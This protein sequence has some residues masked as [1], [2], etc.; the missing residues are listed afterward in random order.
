[1]CTMSSRCE[2]YRRQVYYSSTVLMGSAPSQKAVSTIQEMQSFVISPGFL[3]RYL[4]A[5]SNIQSYAGVLVLISLGL[6]FWA[7]PRY[8][9]KTMLVYL[10]VCSLIGSLSVVA[11]QGL[12]TDFLDRADNRRCNRSPSSRKA[13]IQS[14]VLVCLVS[15]CRLYTP[16]GNHLPQCTTHIQLH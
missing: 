1:V 9:N 7:G 2:C 15:I 13:T 11:T 6:I 10:S 8:G 3:V 5:L 14:V 16:Y 4:S 12:G